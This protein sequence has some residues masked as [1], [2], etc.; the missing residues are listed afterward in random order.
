MLPKTGGHFPPVLLHDGVRNPKDDVWEFIL[1][2]RQVVELVCA[3]TVS[4]SQVAYMKILIEE[5][6]ETR[7]ALFPLRPKHHYLLHYSDLTLQFEPLFAHGQCI[8]KART[9]TLRG[10]FGHVSISETSQNHF[11]SGINCC[12]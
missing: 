6:I 1:L 2:L 9:A 8:L 10:V 7:Q 3:P 11:H 5:Y 4:E 12:K